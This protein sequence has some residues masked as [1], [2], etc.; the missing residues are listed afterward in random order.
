MVEH[1]AIIEFW[2]EHH[3]PR[4]LLRLET[5]AAPPPVGAVVNILSQDYEVFQVDYSVDLPGQPFPETIY[6][7]N[8]YLRPAKAEASNG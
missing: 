4:F 5:A 6:R 7:R 2:V 1:R 8:V 3:Q